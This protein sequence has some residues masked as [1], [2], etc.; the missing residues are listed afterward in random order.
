MSFLGEIYLDLALPPTPAS[1][2]HCGRCT[3]CL[4]ACPTQAIVAPYRLDARRCISYLSIE[5]DGA[6]PEA[7]RAAFGNRVLGCD[8]CQLVCPWNKYAR[9][10]SLPDFDA[11]PGMSGSS[12]LS[13]WAWGEAEFLSRTEGSAIRRIGFRRWQRNLLVAMG[14]AWREEGDPSM[15][16]ALQQAASRV[17]ED[18]MLEE[19]RQWALAQ[20]SR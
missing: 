17:G 13:L 11:R 7:F 3:A 9:R 5:H 10:S 20:R 16:Q 1:S 18:A 12:L 2:A 14:N 19:H 8:E 6:I 15:G 4:D